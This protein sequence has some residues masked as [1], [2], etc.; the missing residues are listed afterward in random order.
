[1]SSMSTRE[2]ERKMLLATRSK[3]LISA[4]RRQSILLI[5]MSSHFSKATK[6]LPLH[7]W[8]FIHLLAP[9]ARWNRTGKLPTPHDMS[10]RV[11]W[12]Q[13]CI[14][15]RSYR[16][17][18]P[19]TEAIIPQLECEWFEINAHIST[20]VPHCLNFRGKGR[21]VKNGVPYLLDSSS[22]AI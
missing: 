18:P 2:G 12:R 5:P 4:N 7:P 16:G 1:M 10:I 14:F 11:R 3:V 19:Y 8:H 9:P 20:S 6:S 21:T 22:G 17:F 13:C 15:D